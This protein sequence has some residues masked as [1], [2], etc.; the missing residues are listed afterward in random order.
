[1]EVNLGNVTNYLNARKQWT[2]PQAIILSN[3]SNGIL[4]GIPQITG[5]EWQDFIILSD[6]NRS[7]I[8]MKQNRVENRRR[9]VNAHMRSYYIADKMT[10]STAWSLLPSRA[11]GERVSYNESGK[12]ESQY[13]DV[14]KYT[15]DGGAGGEDLLRWYENNTG[16]FF[17]FLA[18]DNPSSFTSNAYDGNKLALYSDVI[19]VFFT[20]FDYNIVKRSSLSKADANNYNPS[21]DFWNI[22]VSFEEV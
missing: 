14:I 22:S 11:Y 5:N 2:R 3:N 21:H 20:S 16:S 12:I 13:N 6:H 1:M 15:V 10:I 9:M 19:E 4:N 18:Y 8:S 7:E 17:M